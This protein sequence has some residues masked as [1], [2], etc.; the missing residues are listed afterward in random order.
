MLTTQFKVFGIYKCWS[1][2]CKFQARVY[3][4]EISFSWGES[5]ASKALAAL[6]KLSATEFGGQTVYRQTTPS[7]KNN[8]SDPGKARLLAQQFRFAESFLS[9]GCYYKNE[10]GGAVVSISC[11]AIGAYVL[12]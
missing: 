5:S 4:L 2:L 1:V 8:G 6:V 9:G 11:G 3:I 10:K 7:D 12:L